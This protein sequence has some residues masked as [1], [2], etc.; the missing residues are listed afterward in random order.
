MPPIFGIISEKVKDG[1]TIITI[2][3]KKTKY[4]G[5]LWQTMGDFGKR[6]MENALVLTRAKEKLKILYV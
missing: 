5:V 3:T 6:K 4:Q 2:D 1:I